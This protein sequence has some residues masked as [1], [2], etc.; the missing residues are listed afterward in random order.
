MYGAL[1]TL[2]GDVLRTRSL[3]CMVLTST[4]LVA[5][6]IALVL[7]PLGQ[8]MVN[9]IEPRTGGTSNAGPSPWNEGTP[10]VKATLDGNGSGGTVEP[11]IAQELIMRSDLNGNVSPVS[12]YQPVFLQL[13]DRPNN[14]SSGELK[15]VDEISVKG[16]RAADVDV[17]TFE[18]GSLST[19]WTPSEDSSGVHGALMGSNDT[20]ATWSADPADRGAGPVSTLFMIS[21][22]RSGSYDLSASANDAVSGAQIGGSAVTTIATAPN[23]H[24]RPA[25]R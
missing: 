2:V 9:A 24:S 5:T 14:S 21:F 13:N 22:N 3:I 4:I 19:P 6:V 11:Q 7:T 8:A 10:S 12:A 18:P 16:A 1:T 20:Q 23:V 15:V 25:A 17:R